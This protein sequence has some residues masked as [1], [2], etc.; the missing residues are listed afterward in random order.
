MH[1]EWRERA[2]PWARATLPDGQQ[3]D[4]IVTS[5]ERTQD[6][7]W[8]FHA[9]AILPSRQE[10]PNGHFEAT[11]EPVA[12]TVA[13]ADITPIPGEDYSALPTTGA[14]AGRQWVLQKLHV[15]MNGGASR[16]LHRA[17]CW[18]AHGS[19]LERITTEEAA[20]LL[21]T[22]EADL[23][24]VCRPDRALRR[25]LSRTTRRARPAAVR[26]SQVGTGEHV[27]PR[28]ERGTGGT[29][30]RLKRGTSAPPLLE[31]A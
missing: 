3:L 12:F 7:R 2:G 5:R 1:S 6:G 27:P 8:W 19:T 31:G 23:C 26:V 25:P 4:V 11:A 16:R 29:G 18:Q 30:D 22:A 17:D 28:G 20:R 10:R 13:A 14:V 24:D 9:E 21:H 15:Y